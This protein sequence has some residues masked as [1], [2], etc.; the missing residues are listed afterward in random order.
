MNMFVVA[1]G[2]RRVTPLPGDVRSLLHN[3]GLRSPS[4]LLVIG[5]RK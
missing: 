5:L 4:Q 1:A 2:P 3:V